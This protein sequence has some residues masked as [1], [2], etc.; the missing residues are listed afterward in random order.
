MKFAHLATVWLSL[1]LCFACN[2]KPQE[3]SPPPSSAPAP[4]VS[5]TATT[6][7]S[8]KAEKDPGPMT[9]PGELAW[10]APP[11]FQVA[12]NPNPMRKATY[13][14]AHVAG[15]SEDAELAVSLAGGDTEANITR[16]E[17]QFEGSPKAKRSELQVDG[18]KVIVVEI[19]GA[20]MGGGMGGPSGKKA[21][22]MMLGAMARDGSQGAG[23]QSTFFKLTGPEKSVR[24]A[25]GDF[26]K[27][28]KSLKPQK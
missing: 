2:N 22:F 13:K 10:Q 3:L 14:V 9:A 8:A 28:L 26:Q 4:S 21:N 27:L 11:S 20:F 15:D 7:P 23:A 24:A 17:G 25:Q 19:T 6:A 12:P 16:W 1:G 5:A 18:V